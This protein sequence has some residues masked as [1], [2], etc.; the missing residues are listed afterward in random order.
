MFWGV[1]GWEAGNRT[2]HRKLK[3]TVKPSTSLTKLLTDL[4]ASLIHLSSI[5]IL[6]TSSK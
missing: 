5:Y 6:L 4:S 1:E 3:S 2:E